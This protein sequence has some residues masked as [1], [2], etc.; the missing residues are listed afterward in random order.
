VG[1]PLKEARA[2]AALA[3]SLYP[4]LPGSGNA[5]WKGHVTFATIAQ[6]VGVAEC[7]VGGSKSA[8]IQA[9]LDGVLS[10]RRDRF[11]PLMVEIVRAGLAYRSKKGNPVTAEEI[12]TINGL[13]LDVGFKLP[14]LWDPDFIGALRSDPHASAKARA[15]V[16]AQSEQKASEHARR[17]SELLR[18]QSELFALHDE[19]N[20]AKAGLALE[21]ILNELFA[22][23]GLAPRGSFRVLGEQIDGAFTLHHEVYLVEAKWHKKPVPEAALLAF[24]GKID[25]KSSATRGVFVSLSGVSDEARVAI[26]R[27]KQANFFIMDGHDLS[28]ILAGH[29]AL[30]AFLERRQRILA[31]EGEVSVPFGE[32]AARGRVGTL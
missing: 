19:P 23:F 7:W 9:L 12:T 16:V 10:R 17:R 3:E 27:G 25:G 6:K 20:R 5:A 30:D 18:L 22:L 24:R 31:E 2:V 32:L 28:M 29:I 21:R 13:I 4:F 15:E 11:E 1:L 14:D 26:T 8:A